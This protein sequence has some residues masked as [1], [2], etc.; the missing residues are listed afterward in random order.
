M[1][2]GVIFYTRNENYS[3]IHSIGQLIEP[4]EINKMFIRIPSLIVSEKKLF[5]P[6][7]YQYILHPNKNLSRLKYNHCIFDNCN[8][9]GYVKNLP[10]SKTEGLRIFE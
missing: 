1:V 2:T 6:E 4:T 7:I 5:K 8:Q 9:K 3:E 10:N